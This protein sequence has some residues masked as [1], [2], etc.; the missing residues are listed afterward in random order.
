[1]VVDFLIVDVIGVVAGID[2]DPIDRDSIRLVAVANIPE[3][4]STGASCTNIKGLRTAHKWRLWERELTSGSDAAARQWYY[5][6]N[7]NHLYFVPLS[8]RNISR[9]AGFST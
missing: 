3:Q 2:G 5:N 1:M 8:S 6:Y 7:A 9:M 4:H